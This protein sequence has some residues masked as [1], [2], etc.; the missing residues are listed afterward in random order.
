MLLNEKEEIRD[1]GQRTLPLMPFDA[2]LPILRQRAEWLKQECEFLLRDLRV[3]CNGVCPAKLR[4]H[5]LRPWGGKWLVPRSF[6]DRNLVP[7]L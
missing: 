2:R 3:R 1:V 7:L 4:E 5:N 6:G